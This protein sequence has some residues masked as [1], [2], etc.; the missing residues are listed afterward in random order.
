ML[1]LLKNGWWRV[2][3]RMNKKWFICDSK[4]DLGVDHKE[5]KLVGEEFNIGWIKGDSYVI[6]N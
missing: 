1:V 3:Y 4:L 5:D 6:Q 2:Q